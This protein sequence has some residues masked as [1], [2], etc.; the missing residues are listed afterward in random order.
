MDKRFYTS[1]VTRITGVKRNRLQVWLDKGWMTPSIQKARGQGTRNIFSLH[2][3]Y[4]IALF[5][6]LVEIGVPRKFVGICAQKLQKQPLLGLFLK[7]DNYCWFD[8]YR[9]GE[10]VFETQL[11]FSPGRGKRD[12]LDSY[13]M[14]GINIAK[15]A[16]EIDLKIDREAR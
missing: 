10:G 1:D 2:D 11:V 16:R 8:V 4:V 14:V 5:K 12:S 9:T 6:K 3:L 13:D 7:S 15:F